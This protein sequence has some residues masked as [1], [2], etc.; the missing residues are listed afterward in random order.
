MKCSFRYFS[1][2]LRFIRSGSSKI[3]LIYLI[4][5]KHFFTRKILKISY[6]ALVSCGTHNRASF[7]IASQ[8]TQRRQRS[9]LVVRTLKGEAKKTQIATV[10]YFFYGDNNYWWRMD[11]EFSV[12][13]GKWIE[14]ILQKKDVANN[15]DD[16]DSAMHSEQNQLCW[17]LFLFLY[18]VHCSL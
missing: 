14:N 16:D 13:C 6:V 4:C 11:A 5:S 9:F 10:F 7:I 17:W 15:I 8:G 12:Y 1:S 3:A 2:H 18:I